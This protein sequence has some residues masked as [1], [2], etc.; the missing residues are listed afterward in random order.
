MCSPDRSPP[1]TSLAKS[2]PVGLRQNR[3]VVRGSSSDAGC[4]SA[5]LIP[6]IG[7]VDRVLV[8]IAKVRGGGT[9]NNCSFLNSHG[10][11][12]GFKNC[13]RP[14]L[15]LARGTTRWQI[16]VPFSP[17]L[18]RGKYR[19]VARGVDASGN[20]EKPNPFRNTFNLTAK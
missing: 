2:H 12:T 19:I 13:R 15:L 17:S 8:S 18:P 6:G 1:E 4:A 9:G 11:L 5:N 20:K 16:S 10:K 14:V 3:L 7:R